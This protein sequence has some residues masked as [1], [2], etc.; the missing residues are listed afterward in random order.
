MINKKLTFMHCDHV[1]HCTGAVDKVF[2][3]YASIQFMTSGAIDL[4]YGNRGYHLSGAWVWAAWPGPHTIF[5]ASP[6]HGH[7]DHRYLAFRGTDVNSWLK[8]GLLPCS[9]IRIGRIGA[10]SQDFDRILTYARRND[11]TG[12]M[13]ANHLL[14]A[15]LLMLQDGGYGLPEKD[16]FLALVDDWLFAHRFAK[17]DYDELAQTLGMG[18]STLR[19]K[20]RDVSGQSLHARFIELQMETARLL[21]ADRS[22]AIKEVAHRLGFSDVYYFSKQFRKYV[23]V[24]PATFRRSIQ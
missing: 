5:H 10:L 21:I 20:F 24:P 23:G 22:I 12:K 11:K 16:N 7:W 15:M 17:P 13:V 9:P 4:S 2:Q 6:K 18:Q 19:R 14:E 1:P 3:G 8:S